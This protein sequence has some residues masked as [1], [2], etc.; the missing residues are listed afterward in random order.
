MDNTFE[1]MKS[2]FN[3]LRTT[4][5]NPTMLDQIEMEYYEPPVHLK[6]MAQVRTPDSS[7]LPVQPYDTSNLKSIE[8]AIITYDLGWKNDNRDVHRALEICR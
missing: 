8:K 5:E 2:N 6:S 3:L 1:S 7:S 4:I